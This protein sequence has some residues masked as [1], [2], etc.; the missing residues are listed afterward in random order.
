ML[1]ILFL[2]TL[3]CGGEVPVGLRFNNA[4]FGP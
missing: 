2:T 1:A 3:V 4:G